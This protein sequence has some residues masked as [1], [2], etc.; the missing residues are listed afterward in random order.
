M[1]AEVGEGEE[2]E[3]APRAHD[4]RLAQFD[5]ERRD[6]QRRKQQPQSPVAQP[7]LDFIDRIRPEP[8]ARDA[9]G[10]RQQPR[11][12]HQASQEEEGFEVA[13]HGRRKRLVI[14]G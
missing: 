11:K 12:R 8:A 2:S 4:P 10:A 14:R 7:V 13:A 5:R 6:A 1:Q 9:E 3:H